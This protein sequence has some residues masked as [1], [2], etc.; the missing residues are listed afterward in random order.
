MDIN[1]D[2]LITKYKTEPSMQING[3]FD[4]ILYL[5]Q[6]LQY[7]NVGKKINVLFERINFPH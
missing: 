6:W 2:L 1:L 7:M 4:C 3:D 5:W